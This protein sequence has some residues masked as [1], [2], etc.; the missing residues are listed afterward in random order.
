MGITTCV[1][2]IITNQKT[3]KK[4]LSYSISICLLSSGFSQ[5]V[6]FKWAARVGGSWMDQGYEVSHD[7]F[8]NVYLTGSF[9]DTV[10]FDP[11]AGTYNMT[12]FGATY[13]LKLDSSGN[14]KWARQ[15]TTNGSCYDLKV[16]ADNNVYISGD[17]QDSCDFDP[18]PGQFIIAQTEISD[19]YVLKWGQ[20]VSTVGI[21]EANIPEQLMVYP[22]PTTGTVHIEGG[23]GK[24]IQICNS[25]GGLVYSG[26]TSDGNIDLSQFA[27]G[28]Y[29]LKIEGKG[30]KVIKQ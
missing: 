12:S 15:I 10:D 5:S 6:S 23:G 16:D 29:M 30:V 4:L 11:G 21:E 20:F 7:P 13:A 22:N 19:A 9:D 28:L 17:F 8:G 14:F 3:M 25:Q 27:N 18:T 1:L 26:I 24:Y 2:A